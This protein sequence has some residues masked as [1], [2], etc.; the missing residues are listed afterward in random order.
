MCVVL[1]TEQV[2]F[3]PHSVLLYR[4]HERSSPDYS[5]GYRSSLWPCAR[6]H[7]QRAFYRADGKK[8]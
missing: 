2:A 7:V 5:P 6:L 4:Q 3:Q 8:S 1:T